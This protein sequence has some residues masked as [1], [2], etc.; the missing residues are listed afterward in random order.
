MQSVIIRS[1]F[2][3]PLDKMLKCLLHLYIGFL[4]ITSRT[5]F[6]VQDEVV[7]PLPG[8]EASAYSL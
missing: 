8:E 1:Y 7:L 2:S 6:T 4:A 5:A 3:K